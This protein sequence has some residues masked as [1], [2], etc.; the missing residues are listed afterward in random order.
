MLAVGLGVLVVAGVAGFVY[1]I[2]EGLGLQGLGLAALR[3]MGLGSLL[4]LLVNPGSTVRVSGGAAVVL[5]DE[6]LSMGV[7]G[8]QW[9]A[10]IDTARAIAGTGGTVTRFGSGLSRFDTLP[11]SA[12]TSHLDEAVRAARASGGPVY[13]VTDGEIDDAA[14][15]A[16]SLLQGV[17]TILLPRDT[18]L[19]AALLDVKL[20][21]RVQLDD[22]VRIGL[23]IGT[24]NSADTSRATLDVLLGD[25]VIHTAVLRLP[26][27]PGVAKR[28]LTLR[29]RALSVGPAVLHFRLRMEG[30]SIAGDDERDRVVTVTRQRSVVVVVDPSD[31]E[32]RFLVTELSAI[33]ERSVQSYAR[34]SLDRWVDT[35]TLESVSQQ[36]VRTAAANAGLLVTRGGR[37]PVE[38][39]GVK[40][41]PVW[42]W[43]ASSDT[44]TEFFPGDW[45]LT[46]GV[47][48]SP[49]GRRLG[50]I[51]TDSLPPLTGVIPLVPAADEWVVLT[52][53]RGRRGAERA[54]LL[55]SDSA[56]VRRL[57][58]AGA[59]LWRWS[60][61]GGA[62]RE[63]YRAVLAAGV[64][65]LL[66]SEVVRRRAV[67][68]A[69]P[70]VVRGD[71][72]VFRWTGDSIPDS[73]TVSF[74]PESGSN[75]ITATLRFD[76]SG[77]ATWLLD[78]G[79]YAWSTPTLTPRL[80][81]QSVVERYS[82]EY[83]PRP[84]TIRSE[85]AG[86]GTTL[87]ERFAREKWWLFVIVVAAFAVEWALRHRRGLP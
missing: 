84:V 66:G 22:S 61:R 78:P 11:P 72:T 68:S 30:D 3:T 60:F 28:T 52:A 63:A 32:G 6:S 54:V 47:P 70:V 13:V 40:R 44:L 57:V 12:G 4:L 58:T 69:S 37:A 1:V 15:I 73:L 67:L 56:G 65:W 77:V 62:A 42:H 39:P 31:W 82:D 36:T 25:R 23:T 34:I 2:R 59:G 46:N 41:R 76:A 87:V 38:V 9:N 81:G 18:L 71:P 5:L 51:E 64:D 26:P 29:P 27:S 43:P 49:L 85:S 80:S 55:G 86:L 35:R 10:A 74:A 83:H 53:R 50:G 7:N 14:T 33:L 19:N 45:Y 24:W 21:D 8:G 17:T 75:T 48:P 16:P 79:V 20:P